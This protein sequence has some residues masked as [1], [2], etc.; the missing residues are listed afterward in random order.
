[1]RRA[2]FGDGGWAAAGFVLGAII[3][4]GYFAA[5][6]AL[7]DLRLATLDYNLAY[8]QETYTERSPFWY[9]LRFPVEQQ[10]RVAALTKWFNA[11]GLY[12]NEG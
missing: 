11:V 3:V 7:T 12:P 4:L 8:S 5:A 6:G 10:A 1:M 2:W 9:P